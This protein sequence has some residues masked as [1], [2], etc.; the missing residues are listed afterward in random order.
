MLGI[1]NKAN[2]IILILSTLL[3]TSFSTIRAAEAADQ[4]HEQFESGQDSAIAYLD[5]M[6]DAYEVINQLIQIHDSSPY[7]VDKILSR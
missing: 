5:N 2:L 7:A 6:I 1:V 3:I 4:L